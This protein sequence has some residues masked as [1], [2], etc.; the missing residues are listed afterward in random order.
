[1]DKYAILLGYFDKQRAIV[2]RMHHEVVNL[3]LSTWENG[4]V[5]AL[6]TQQLFTALEDLMKQIAKAF[7]NHIED[8]GSFHRE[9]LLR[10]NTEVPTIRP[11]VLSNES[12]V[13]L[14][15]LRA[16]RHFIR[17]G[18]G[19][20]LDEKQLRALQEQMRLRF[21]LLETDLSTFRN[22]IHKLAS[23]LD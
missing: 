20:E 10:M 21:S 15:K 6:K 17:H 1:M 5:F 19:C 9:I 22:Y 4:Y 14:D 12:F 3:D 7:E 18:Y 13:L 23:D 8:L 11:A 16:F 2:Q